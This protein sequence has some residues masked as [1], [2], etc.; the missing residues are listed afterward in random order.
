[1]LCRCFEKSLYDLGNPLYVRL[2]EGDA[3]K[4]IVK[5]SE[6]AGCD[7]IVMGSRGLSGLREWWLGSVSH[8]VMQH[9]KRLVLIVK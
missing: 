9:T 6:E 5:Y 1:M 4:E 8:H 2:K 3:G 7:L